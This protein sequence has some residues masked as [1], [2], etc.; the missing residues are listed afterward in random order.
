MMTTRETPYLGSPP[1]GWMILDAVL[2]VVLFDL[3]QNGPEPLLAA[4]QKPGS[5]A[6]AR[7]SSRVLYLSSQ[8]SSMRQPLNRLFTMI[9]SPFSWGC[10]QVAKRL[11]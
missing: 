2:R 11:W 4:G 6:H 9:V 1:E 3:V 5:A 7:K 10:Q 8:T